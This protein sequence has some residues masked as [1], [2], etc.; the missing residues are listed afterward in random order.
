M[1]FSFG[2]LIGNLFGL[3]VFALLLCSVLYFVL[4]VPIS[5]KRITNELSE[6]KQEL[7]RR[8]RSGE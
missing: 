3:F 2:T 1:E 6:I 8:N 4:L 5:L 7:R